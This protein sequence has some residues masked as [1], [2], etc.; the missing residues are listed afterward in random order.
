[1][2]LKR[3]IELMYKKIGVLEMKLVSSFREGYIGKNTYEVTLN[4]GTK[5]MIDQIVKGDNNG[6]AVIIVPVTNDD[7]VVVVLESRPMVKSGVNLGFPAGMVDPGE[8]PYDAA[9]RELR[10]E[11]GYE[12]KEIVPIEWH[13][14]DQGCSKAIITTFLAKGCEKKYDTDFDEG[15]RLEATEVTWDEIKREM[16]DPFSDNFKDAGSKIAY[17]YANKQR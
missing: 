2:N 7:K 4:D 6:D 15:E 12:A 14:Q 8:N 16:E 11:T 1:M 9:V 13:Y 17:F 10:E 3:F 5:K